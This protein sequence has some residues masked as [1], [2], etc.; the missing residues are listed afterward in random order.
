MASRCNSVRAGFRP[1]REV[2]DVDGSRERLSGKRALVT[3]GASGIG[4]EVARRFLEEGAEVVVADLAGGDIEVDVRSRASVMAGVSEAAARLGGL[5]TVVCNAGRPVLGAVDELPE[6]EWDDGAATN[7]KGV[8]LTVK[9]AWPYLVESRGC[10]LSTASTLGLMAVGGQAAYCAFKA[11]VVMLTKCLA[12]DGAREGI[13]ANCVCPGMIETPMLQGILAQQPDPAG[14]RAAATSYHPLG[15][16]GRAV[17]IADAF[18]YL[19]S[20]DANWVTGVAL[21]VDGGFTTGKEI[22]F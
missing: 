18:V 10:V 17:D 16:L 12:L 21:V 13:R 4:A 5:T 22:S 3:G 11:G 14:A 7:L 6:T 9:S 2:G 15:R 1:E 20:D 8:Y 19:A